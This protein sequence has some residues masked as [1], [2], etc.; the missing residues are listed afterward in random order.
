MA[1]SNNKQIPQ[2]WR[3]PPLDCPKLA[4]GQRL[5]KEKQY[6]EAACCF[7]SSIEQLAPEAITTKD[8]AWTGDEVLLSTRLFLLH[9]LSS[10]PGHGEKTLN[11]AQS[12]L[13]VIT[14]SGCQCRP[15]LLIMIYQSIAG[16]VKDEILL[17]CNND[18]ETSESRHDARCEIITKMGISAC[19][20]VL[21]ESSYGST[22]QRRLFYELEST[23]YERIGNLQAAA[24]STQALLKESPKN[25]EQKRRLRD[26]HVRLGLVD[27]AAEQAA[28]EAKAE[29]L[30][31]KKRNKRRRKDKQSAHLGEILTKLDPDVKAT[32]NRP[33]NLFGGLTRVSKH[34]SR[35]IDWSSIPSEITPDYSNKKQDLRLRRK[36][37]QLE[38]LF[39]LLSDM[40]DRVAASSNGES[41]RHP[42]HIVDFGSG[43]G[44]S[45]LVFAFLLRD[46]DIPC[47]FT[48][49]DN[50]PQSVLLGKERTTKAG[51][52]SIVSWQCQDVQDFNED[53]DIGL[54][55]HLC[56]GAT[57]IAMSKC[58]KQ[59]AAFIAT[60][61]CLGAIQFAVGAHNDNDARSNA[62]E[63]PR[64]A[65]FRAKLSVQDYASMT[66]LADCCIAGDESDNELRMQGKALLDSDRLK[67]AIEED[68]ET[69]FGQL[70]SKVDCGPKSDVL[71]GI[72]KE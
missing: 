65:W 58:L 19:R 39:V 17:L 26:L 70:G 9:A 33:S 20:G 45:C 62:L 16:F 29:Q 47:R 31:H 38:A 66:R 24:E 71:C 69:A 2:P 21:D 50:K 25:E 3:R 5:L 18:N 36:Q 4:E 51:L 6:G 14:S 27:E 64:S 41:R 68:Y 49:I 42:L 1:T 10:A 43:S 34:P 54:A 59:K 7:R 48:L 63:Y 60:P 52:D 72:C 32:L 23:L 11:E 22:K 55:T 28:A 37:A 57:D 53:F 15:E 30:A 46:I 12:I 67:L 61:C 40:V 8:G 56:G 35:T 44:N 13:S